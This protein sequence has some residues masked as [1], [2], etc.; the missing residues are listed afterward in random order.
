MQLSESYRS[1]TGTPVK[2]GREDTLS[3]KRRIA[4]IAVALTTMGTLSGAALAFSAA[5]AFAAGGSLANVSWSVSNNT[6]NQNAATTNTATYTWA[7]TTATTATLTTIDLTVPSGTTGSSLGVT[8]YGLGGASVTAALASGTVTA[9]LTGGGS[10]AAGTPV[11]LVITGFTNGTTTG[12]QTSTVTTNDA[13]GAV[14]TGTTNAI[15]FANN[16]TAVTVQVPQSL[17][18]TNNK[19]AITLLPVPNTPAVEAN[20]ATLTVST[21][22]QSGYTLSACSGSLSGPGA[23]TIGQQQSAV[24][25]L[26]GSSFGASASVSAGSV[27]SPSVQTPWA[28]GTYIGYAGTC[29]A[30]GTGGGAPSS[31]V[32]SDSGPASLDTLTLTNSAS[33]SATQQ[34]GTYTGTINYLVTPSY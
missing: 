26:S 17:T 33:V 15:D 12:S 14:D 9:T 11:E 1:S 27:G 31:P 23:A 7:F 2:K 32:V 30:T 22:A 4:R 21:N 8:A 25:S 24:S 18:F 16:T 20:P 6:T 28:S 19:T 34:A 5:P 13:S 3:T 10:I 29:S